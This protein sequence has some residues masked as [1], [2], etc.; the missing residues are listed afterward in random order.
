MA[1]LMQARTPAGE[2]G[3]ARRGL[4]GFDYEDGPYVFAALG[5]PPGYR[6]AI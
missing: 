3:D 5:Q 4:P 2:A 1:S 6:V